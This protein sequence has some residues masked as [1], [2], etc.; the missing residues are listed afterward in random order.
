[1]D[2]S[3]SCNA[4]SR[5][6][7]DWRKTQENDYQNIMKSSIL[8]YLQPRVGDARPPPPGAWGVQGAGESGSFPENEV[9]LTSILLSIVTLSVN[10]LLIFASK[11]M[12]HIYFG[13]IPVESESRLS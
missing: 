6:Q 10:L 4:N 2:P 11:C 13:D 1:M 12:L 8:E 9:T 3:L 5:S 7:N